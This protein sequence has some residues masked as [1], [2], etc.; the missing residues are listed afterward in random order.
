MS[1]FAVFDTSSVDRFRS[2]SWPTPDALTTR[3]TPEHSPPRLL[4]RMPQR[5]SRAGCKLAAVMLRH[6]VHRQSLR[7]TPAR[8][9]SDPIV[10]FLRLRTI[11]RGFPL[12][13]ASTPSTSRA[14]LN[15]CGQ[16]LSTTWHS[17]LSS[18][19]PAAA[20][21]PGTRARSISGLPPRWR[22]SSRWGHVGR[23]QGIPRRGS[24]RGSRASRCRR[25]ARLVAGRIRLPLSGRGFPK[26]GLVEFLL[27]RGPFRVALGDG[28]VR[29]RDVPFRTVGTVAHKGADVPRRSF[30]FIASSCLSFRRP[31][32]VST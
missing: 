8:P 31:S 26:P 2:P 6:R 17:P 5:R 1:S 18:P 15:S 4:S 9:G 32:T 21:T 23:S 24:R 10:M 14:A 7:Q 16:R 27:R 30:R 11:L 20:R 19:P 13:M 28:L 29:T 22:R 12:A 25:A 3:L